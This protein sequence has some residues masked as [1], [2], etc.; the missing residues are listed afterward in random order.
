MTKVTKALCGESID[1]SSGASQISVVYKQPKELKAVNCLIESESL[2]HPLRTQSTKDYTDD[3]GSLIYVNGLPSLCVADGLCGSHHLPPQLLCNHFFPKIA[4]AF[5]TRL[6]K[7]EDSTKVMR[8]LLKAAQEFLSTLSKTKFEYNNAG[9]TFSCALSY[10]LEGKHY[11]A[12][13]GIGPDEIA[14]QRGG[15]FKRLRPSRFLILE[16]DENRLNTGKYF[17][18]NKEALPLTTAMMGLLDCVEVFTEEL[19]PNDF[20]VGM[21]DG[22]LEALH[23]PS[24]KK[25]VVKG[26]FGNE[27]VCVQTIA[28]SEQ[29][30]NTESFLLLQ[31]AKEANVKVVCEAGDSRDYPVG[32]DALVIMAQVPDAQRKKAIMRAS[33]HVNRAD[34]RMSKSTVTLRAAQPAVLAGTADE[35]TGLTTGKTKAKRCCSMM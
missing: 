12:S 10:Q 21:T 11:V 14:I 34:M 18:K 35:R 1:L 7:G 6:E 16:K 33:H 9:C 5:V 17:R 26:N 28:N 19:E 20:L 22:I 24:E 13:T 32:D 31:T 23:L 8:E 29:H 4:P 27:L 2:F 25:E 3:A 15:Q 30:K